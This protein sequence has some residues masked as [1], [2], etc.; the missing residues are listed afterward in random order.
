LN[1]DNGSAGFEIS[2]NGTLVYIEGGLDVFAV[3]DLVDIKTRETVE[4]LEVG[5]AF[6]AVKFSPDGS[7]LALTLLGG[8][9]FDVAIWERDRE[10]LSQLTFGDDNYSPTWNP[11]GDRLAFRS[12][13][14]GRYELWSV[15]ADG[16]GEPELVVDGET[17]LPDGKT[18]W[19]ADGRFLLFSDVTSGASDIWVVD[20]E[21]GETRAIVASMAAEE[22]PAFSPD[23]DFVLWSSSETGR[24]EIFAMPFP[25]GGGKQQVSSAGGRYARWAPSGDRIFYVGD[26]GVMEVPVTISGG[27][28]ELGRPRLFLEISAVQ[29]LA[30][31]SDGT[32]M[33]IGRHPLETMTSEVRVVLNWF[34]ELKRLVPTD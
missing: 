3:T 19:S 28:L 18:A 32:T 2:G 26:T 23:G 27:A 22:D 1:L 14:G 6:E 10:V 8:G 12:N 13:R 15:A 33:A 21:S 11:S 20:V 30:I 16:S 29:H 25:A 9:M 24:Y 5:A 4:R 34:E 31:S 17:L 7:R